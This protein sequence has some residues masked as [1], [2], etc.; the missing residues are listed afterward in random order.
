MMRWAHHPAS[1]GSLLSRSRETANC[2]R[3]SSQSAVAAAPTREARALG[4]SAAAASKSRSH[5]TIETAMILPLFGN[6]RDDDRVDGLDA[7]ARRVCV[8]DVDVPSP[9]GEAEGG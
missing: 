3:S 4:S 2:S 6:G 1:L 7:H 9:H 5:D 8:A